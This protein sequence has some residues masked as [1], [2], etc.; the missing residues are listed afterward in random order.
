[1]E[2]IILLMKEKRGNGYLKKALM[3]AGKQRLA[4]NIS[5]RWKWNHWKTRRATM[6]PFRQK[7]PDYFTAFILY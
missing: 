7:L 6:K 4:G 2:L 5:G 3:F 1:M